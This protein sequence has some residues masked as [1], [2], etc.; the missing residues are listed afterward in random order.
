MKCATLLAVFVVV[1]I[2]TSCARRQ[3]V[4]S[5]SLSAPA[6]QAQPLPPPANSPLAK[7]SPGMGM[8]EVTE[9]I[10]RPTD[11]VVRRTGKMFI[12]YYYGPDKG[13]IIWLYKG[14][15]KVV[16]STPGA[17]WMQEEIP[18]VRII[19]YDPNEVGYS[20]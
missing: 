8:R 15:G 4:P 5:G 10:G 9:L 6:P 7:V 18:R 12:P 2:T 19:E 17:S 14:Q 20:R 11:I 16:F 1:W 3:P 13:R